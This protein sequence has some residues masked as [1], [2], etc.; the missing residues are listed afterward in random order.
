MHVVLSYSCNYIIKPIYS[1]QFTGKIGTVFTV[2]SNLKHSFKY[3]TIK[4]SHF[5]VVTLFLKNYH[6]KKERQYILIH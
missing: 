3:V 2:S 5:L 1:M 4:F 6:Y